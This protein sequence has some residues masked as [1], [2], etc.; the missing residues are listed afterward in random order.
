MVFQTF[1]IRHFTITTSLW[2][3]HSIL[4]Y[5][6]GKELETPRKRVIFPG[7]HISL[8][9]ESGSPSPLQNPTSLRPSSCLNW[10]TVIKPAFMLSPK[11]H[12]P[13]RSQWSAQGTSG[14]VSY[15][16]NNTLLWL[17]TNQSIQSKAIP[18][19]LWGPSITSQLCLFYRNPPHGLFEST[20]TS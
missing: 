7:S 11:V 9:I 15:P 13:H 17:L 16:V 1:H 2:G 6:I 4:F 5:V 10:T 18:H 14:I 19:G 12:S 20:H 8:K 3:R